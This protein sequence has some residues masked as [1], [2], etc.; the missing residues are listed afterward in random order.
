M[1]V[2]KLNIKARAIRI[3]P[4][5]DQSIGD[6]Q[7]AMRVEFYVCPPCYTTT[8]PPVTTPQSSTTPS[9]STESSTTPTQSTTESSTTPSQSTTVATTTKSSTTPPQSTTTPSQTTT[10]SSTT[11]SHSTTESSTTPSQSTTESSTTP[12]QSTTKASSTPSQSTTESSTTP[13]S[14]TTEAS[15]TSTPSTNPPTTAPI[16]DCKNP[17]PVGVANG[18]IPDSQMKSN[19]VKVPSPGPFYTGPGQARLNNKLT[20]S[21]SGAWEPKDKEAHLDIIFNKMEDVR[22]IRT[23]GSPR[24]SKF[25]R[26]YFIFYSLDGEKFEE[27]PLQTVRTEFCCF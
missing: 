24:L 27:E 5:N 23:Q 17:L 4:A 25:A 3:I 22:E 26:R 16:C 18:Q 9:Q 14:S 2:N 12:S 1:K 13:K 10:E 6:P 8:L 19:S 7:V 15:T 21:G 20:S 11:P